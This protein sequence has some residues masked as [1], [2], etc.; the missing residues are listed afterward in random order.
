M[1]F[2]GSLEEP[3]NSFVS[4]TSYTNLPQESHAI[5]SEGLAYRLRFHNRRT[6][7]NLVEFL[8]LGIVMWVVLAKDFKR[9]F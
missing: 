9:L 6:R 8:V 1:G 7:E 5:S 2:V 3:H 4:S